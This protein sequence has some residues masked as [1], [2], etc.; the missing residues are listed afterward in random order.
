MTYYQ[1]HIRPRLQADQE[2]RGLN[3]RIEET[4]KHLEELRIEKINFETRFI[5]A[6]FYPSAED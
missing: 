2:Y 4:A 1:E 6:R 3:R 5:A